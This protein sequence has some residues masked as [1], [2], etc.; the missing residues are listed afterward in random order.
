M[1]SRAPPA[2][3][4]GDHGPARVR[5]WSTLFRLAVGLALLCALVYLG[6]ID[7]KILLQLTDAPWAI[8]T[9]VG[10][11]WLSVPLAALRWG[12]LLRALGVPIPFGN[13]FHF[14]AIGLLTNVLLL[15]TAGGD[16]VRALY[17]WRALGRGGGRVAVSVLADRLLTL[18]GALF[19]A[20][21]FTLFHWRRMQQEPALAAL[22]TSVFVAVAACIMGACALF[23]APSM[24]HPLEQALPR[25]AQ[26]VVQVREVI[27]MLRTNPLWLLSAFALA[28]ATQILAVAAVFVIAEAVKIDVLSVADLMF[29]VPL[30]LVVNALPLTPSGL[31]VGEAAFDQ[32]CRWLEPVPSGAAYSTIFFGF[33]VGSTL[34]C[35][36]GL[37]SLAIYRKAVR[38]ERI[39]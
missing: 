8:A 6:Q 36:P 29:A 1:E 20:L 38:S 3:H 11:V 7:L 12:I 28:L 27:L 32:I 26:L 14:V 33:R 5:V 31:G 23:V 2:G 13:L 25:A 37:V 15:G 9:L 4:S 19:F 22:G 18:L 10:S 39:E 21:V 35:L 16:A 34:A 24:T 30:T 17:A